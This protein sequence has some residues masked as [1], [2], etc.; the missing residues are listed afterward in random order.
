MASKST[1]VKGCGHCK[2]YQY[3]GQ[4]PARKL[5]FHDL[6]QLG[7][8]RRLPVRRVIPRHLREWGA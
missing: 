1:R 4:G 6:R 7:I 8:K 3:R 5:P 2:I